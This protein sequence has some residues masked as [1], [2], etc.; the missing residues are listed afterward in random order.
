MIEDNANANALGL[1]S[2]KKSNGTPVKV[3]V[4][5]V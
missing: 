2:V 5:V 1:S 4:K 3:T